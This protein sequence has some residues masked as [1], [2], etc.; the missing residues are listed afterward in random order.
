MGRRLRWRA[1]LGSGVL[2]QDFSPQNVRG[3]ER[4]NYGDRYCSAI[5]LMEYRELPFGDR[6]FRRGYGF[7]QHAVRRRSLAAE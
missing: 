2:R 3:T 5:L 7:A 1:P 4:R 6:E